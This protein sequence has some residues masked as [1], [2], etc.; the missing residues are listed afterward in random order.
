MTEKKIVTLVETKGTERTYQMNDGSIEKRTGGTVA[1]RNNNPGNL[2]F[3]YA[4]SADHTVRHH[5]Q[6]KR[7]CRQ[8]KVNMK[9]WLAIG[10]VG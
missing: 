2:K 3:E 4:N 7:H 8:L 9:V 6:R 5:G 1:W 10:S